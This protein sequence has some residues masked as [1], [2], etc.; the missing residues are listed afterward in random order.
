VLGLLY[1]EDIRELMRKSFFALQE[2]KKHQSIKKAFMEKL[3]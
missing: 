2:D 1:Y 3:S